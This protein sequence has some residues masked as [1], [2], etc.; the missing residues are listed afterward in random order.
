[1]TDSFVPNFEK[2]APAQVA[3]WPKL[4]PIAR[5]GFVLYGG[6]GLSTRL[7]HRGSLDFDFFASRPIDR[8]GLAQDLPFLT[9]A[10]T[11]QNERDTYTV[12]IPIGNNEVK[13]SFFGA[14]NIK[15]IGEPEFTDDG[16]CRVASLDDLA[17]TKLSAVLA[18][19]QASDYRDV[20]AIVR[21]GLPLEEAIADTVAIYGTAFQPSDILKALTYFEGGDLDELTRDERAELRAIVAG[22]REI[23]HRSAISR[24]LSPEP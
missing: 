15:R 1:M 7:G 12:S 8:A 18:R 10:A 3:I 23:P 16:V 17:A 6:M 14:L 11:L 19:I 2:F 21:T 20:L 4:A 24:E 13:I 22:V 5:H 9:T